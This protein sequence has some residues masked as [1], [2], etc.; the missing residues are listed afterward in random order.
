MLIA[1]IANAHQGRPSDA[2]K[3]VEAAAEAGCDAVK[4]QKYFAS[5]MLAP[6]HGMT[7]TFNRL[8]WEEAAWHE[9]FAAAKSVNLKVFVDVFGVRAFQSLE[10]LPPVD[11]L[12]LHGA[13]VGNVP[14]L[15]LLATTACPILIGTGG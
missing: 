7:E 13:D 2:M 6:G 5:E 1:E 8:E 4:F 12:K 14:L 3:L 11:G 9:L 15:D 10:Q